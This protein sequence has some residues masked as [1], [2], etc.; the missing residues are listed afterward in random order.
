MLNKGMNMIDDQNEMIR[1][2]E[3]YGE[4]NEV[5]KMTTYHGVRNRSNGQSAEVEVN[6]FDS[7][8]AAGNTRYFVVA[9][10][11]REPEVTASGNPAA[12]LDVTLA[13]VHWSDLD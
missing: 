12:K 2:L 5:S 6:I 4:L 3:K 8:E 11:V 13:T 1:Q 9:H 10:L 7:G